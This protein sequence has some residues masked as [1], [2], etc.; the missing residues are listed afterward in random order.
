MDLQEAKAMLEE[1]KVDNVRMVIVDIN[2]TPVGKRLPVGK[3]LSVC[4]RGM[5]FCSGI[6][7]LL[8]DS[9]IIPELPVIGGFSQ[10]F[11]DVVAWPDLNTLRPVAW[12]DRTALVICDMRNPD[13]KPLT[14]T[15]A[16][17]RFS[18]RSP[19]L[20]SGLMGTAKLLFVKK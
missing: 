8:G 16:K 11:P 7:N 3:F 18:A 9:D 20:K 17:A 2:G 4:D 6:Y 14:N 5:S 12:E 13:E 15:N 19:L 10:G 1:H